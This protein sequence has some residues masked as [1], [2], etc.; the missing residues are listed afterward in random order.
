MTL[1]QMD[2]L[3]ITLSAYDAVVVGIHKTNNSPSKH[4][5]ITNSTVDF[6]D[7]LANKTKVVLNVFANPYSLRYFTNSKQINSIL[8]SY[9]DHSL[10]QDLSAQLLFGGIPALGKLPVTA[11]KDFPV[12]TGVILNNKIRLKYSI[13]EEVGV[14]RADL[15]SVDSIV[16]DAIAKKASPGGQLLVAK[17]GVV[18]INKSYGY[19]TYKK[20]NKVRN[21]D[22]YD[23]ASITKIVSTIP[24]LMRLHEKGN[25]DIDKTLGDYM[26][27]VDSTNKQGMKIKE[28]LTHQA[29]LQ[30]W[31]PFYLRTIKDDATR[32]Y[33]YSKTQFL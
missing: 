11:S 8:I 17:D 13:P 29:R 3:L 5:G 15:L 25:F 19:H 23:I 24:A 6:V 32:T 22:L 26:P 21:P 28:V 33:A 30:K 7:K 4:F 9:E 14:D 16:E 18:F 12:G 1:T 27:F 31:I 20:E 2:A 10:S